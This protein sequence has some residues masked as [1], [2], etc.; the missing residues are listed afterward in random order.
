MRNPGSNP[1]APTS[2]PFEFSHRFKIG[3]DIRFS[4]CFAV[5][6]GLVLIIEGALWAFLPG[7]GRK[8]LEATASIPEL[9]LRV[10]GAAAVAAGVLLI[11]VARG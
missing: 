11:W 5:A 8:L 10:A 9:S 3:S 4:G 1:S 7:L 6:F 2:Y